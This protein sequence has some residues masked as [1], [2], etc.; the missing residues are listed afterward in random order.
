MYGKCGAIHEAEYMFSELKQPTIV[1]WTAML[2]AYVEQGLAERALEMY[3]RMH[4]EDMSPNELTFVII[5]QACGILAEK[6]DSQERAIKTLSLERGHELHS[7]AF[8]RGYELETLVGTLLLTMFN[9]S[10]GIIRR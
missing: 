3:S 7:D 2:S 5:L 8:M 1:S 10:R 6:E 9:F 4:E